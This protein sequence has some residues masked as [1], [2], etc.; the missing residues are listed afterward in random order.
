M[1]YEGTLQNGVSDIERQFTGADLKWP[2]A[3]RPMYFLIS[4]GNEEMASTGTS[5]LNRTEAASVEKIVTMY[6]KNGITPDQIGVITPYEGQRAYLVAYM[7]RSGSL[8]PELYKDIEVA[9]VDSFQ[10]R[11]K[12]FI[13]VS[14]VRS[15]VQQGIGFL[16]DPR[17]L[18]G[19][20]TKQSLSWK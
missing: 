16:R 1:F 19:P 15:N 7:Q 8:R 2:N 13:I 20:S 17:R 18:N 11:E 10:G 9:S 14:S 3:S 12:D 6:L 5:F 4:T